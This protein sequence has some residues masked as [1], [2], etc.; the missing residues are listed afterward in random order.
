[1]GS[2]YGY[3]TVA[4]LEAYTGINYETTSAVYT[5]AFVEAQI[6]IAERVVNA[7]CVVAPG[8]TDGVFAATMI[9]SE[10]FM[11]NVMITD[12]FA[13][14]IEQSIKAFFDYLIELIL[15]PDRYS[16]MSIVPMSGADR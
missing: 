13:D 8:V 12:G 10:R 1:M 9:L 6:S 16:P 11:R 14:N 5:D 7:M 15:K 3:I 4:Q 2:T